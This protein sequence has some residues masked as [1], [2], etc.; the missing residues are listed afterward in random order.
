MRRISCSFG[1][2]SFSGRTLLL[3]VSLY[4]NPLRLRPA[5]FHVGLLFSLF[6]PFVGYAFFLHD[7]T[8]LVRGIFCTLQYV[9][10]SN[11]FFMPLFVFILHHSRSFMTL[12]IFL[13]VFRA[14][15]LSAFLFSVVQ[16]TL[17]PHK[18]I[19]VT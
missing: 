5:I 11:M 18:Y 7:H 16:P 13:T 4:L 9:P 15:I 1:H 2:I 3:G 19:W 8:I 12:F 14:N 6:L 17:M 10:H